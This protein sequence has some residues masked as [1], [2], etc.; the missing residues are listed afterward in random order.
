MQPTYPISLLACAIVPKVPALSSIKC[1][2][3]A[4]SP[5]DCCQPSSKYKISPFFFRLTLVLRPHR[6]LFCNVGRSTSVLSL[7]ADNW[8]VFDSE[9]LILISI[10]NFAFWLGNLPGL[11][12][13]EHFTGQGL[14]SQA[15]RLRAS[16]GRTNWSKHPRL[17][18]GMS[19]V[20]PGVISSHPS[21][22]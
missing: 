17:N 4:S 8:P 6:L 13:V 22:R 16:P 20:L 19:S 12:D 10:P 21:I 3:K 5:A 11:Q 2:S 18:C 9:K 15:V 1:L 14:Q 7:F